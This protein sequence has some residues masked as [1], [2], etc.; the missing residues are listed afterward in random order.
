MKWL[1]QRMGE[2]LVGLADTR[3]SRLFKVMVKAMESG[4]LLQTVTKTS[5]EYKMR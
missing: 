3:P 4:C 1:A 5:Y 2:R